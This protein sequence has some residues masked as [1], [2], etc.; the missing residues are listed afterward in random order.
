M[1]A[2]QIKASIQLS[3]GT[4]DKD[5]NLADGKS[6]VR[7]F[8]QK[9]PIQL[10]SSSQDIRAVSWQCKVEHDTINNVNEGRWSLV[11]SS[12][13]HFRTRGNKSTWMG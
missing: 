4:L 6:L 1:V 12:Q 13:S 5:M 9:S 10:S 2:G 7:S 8:R 3:S 11:R